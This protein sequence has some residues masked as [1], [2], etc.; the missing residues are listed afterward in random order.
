[1]GEG[2]LGEM[3]GGVTE[4]TEGEKGGV[5]LDNSIFIMNTL[6]YNKHYTLGRYCQ[7]PLLIK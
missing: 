3:E 6:K 2:R 7:F 4:G 5:K 1:M